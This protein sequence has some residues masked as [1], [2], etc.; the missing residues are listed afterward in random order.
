MIEDP[1]GEVD[2]VPVGFVHVVSRLHLLIQLSK[3]QS[4]G[5]FAFEVDAREVV[6]VGEG[7][8]FT[9]HLEH[10]RRFPKG[11]FFGSARLGEAIF[12][13]FLYVHGLCFNASSV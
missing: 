13:E 8:Y 7:E 11:K 3:Q 10:Q 6:Q 9:Y 4:L 2:G 12:P 5:R 1:S